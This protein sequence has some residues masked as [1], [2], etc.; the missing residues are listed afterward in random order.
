MITWENKKLSVQAV[1]KQGWIAVKYC[2]LWVLA[3]IEIWDE[4][5]YLET[6]HR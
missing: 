3:N 4:K 6:F 5:K 2:C 1:M